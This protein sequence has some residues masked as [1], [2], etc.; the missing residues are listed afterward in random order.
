MSEFFK[1]D[2][3]PAAKVELEEL[4]FKAGGKGHFKS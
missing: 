2:I 4:V 3:P 1:T